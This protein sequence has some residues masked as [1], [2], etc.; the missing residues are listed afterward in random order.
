VWPTLVPAAVP[1][2][3]KLQLVEPSA[4]HTSDGEAEN[5]TGAPTVPVAGM[6]G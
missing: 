3:P 2:S 1:P 5:E 6:E 4:D